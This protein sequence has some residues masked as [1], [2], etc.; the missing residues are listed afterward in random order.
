MNY[1]LVIRNGTIVDGSGAPAYRGDVGVVGD[2]IAAIGAITDKG[3]QEIDAEGHYVT[4]GFVDGHTHMDAQVFWDELGTNSCWHG[5]TSVVMGNCG[6]TLAPASYEGRELAVANLERAEDIA[7]TSLEAGIDWSWTSFP[8][9]LDAVDRMPKGLNYAANI[10]HSPL[11]TW[12]MGEAAFEREATPDELARMAEQ[13][14]EAI[15]AGAVGFTTSRSINHETPDDLPVASRLASWDEVRALVGVLGEERRGV[16]EIA[17]EAAVA[18][19]DPDERHEYY[20]RLR[21]LAL[22]TGV[23][24]TFGLFASTIGNELLAVIDDV[25]ASGGTMFGLT[26]CRGVGS[27]MS[28]LTRM[29]FDGFTEW[30]KIRSL[31]HAQQLAALKDPAVRARLVDDADTAAFGRAIGAEARRPKYERMEVMRSAHLRNATVAQEATARGTSPVEAIIDIAIETEL[32]ALFSQVIAPQ[33]E[34]LL[35]PMLRH[36]ATAMTFSDSGAHVSQ[37]VDSS[38]QT[39]LLASMVRDREIFTWEEAVRMITHR[40]ALHWHLQDR[41]L[42]QTGMMADINVFDPD[43]IAPDLPIVADDLPGGG[44]RYLQRATGIAA[45][46]VNGTVLFRNGEETGE[47][48]GRLL[49]GGAAMA[50]G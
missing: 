29:P 32:K 45:T 2:R 19:R 28:F 16:F 3:R 5:V 7:R 50:N 38:I 36:P 49:R 25:N 44:R 14:R 46:V 40:P 31:P 20:A 23:P 47:R 11:R 35:F 12:N 21:A 33:P 42:L 41:G 34:E 10:G 6:F 15:R 17:N 39:Y 30:K 48:P 9:Y 24:V 18:S 22:D 13:V 8:E 26:H 43:T 1:D 27:V 4:P 37:I